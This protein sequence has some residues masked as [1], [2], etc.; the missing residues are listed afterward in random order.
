MLLLPWL[1][2]GMLKTRPDAL[3]SLFHCR[4]ACGPSDWER[5][6]ISPEGTQERELS[7]VWGK[8]CATVRDSL[9]RS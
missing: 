8:A 6:I 5:T 9:L 1:N 7:E 3:L 2:I 4:S